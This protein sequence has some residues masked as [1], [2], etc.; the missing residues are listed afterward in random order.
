MRLYDLAP[1][2]ARLVADLDSDECNGLDVEG[3]LAALSEAIEEKAAHLCHVIADLD[4]EGETLRAEEKRLA[5]RRQA[6]ENRAESL[7]DYLRTGMDTAGI[8]KV[9]SATHTITVSDGPQKCVVYDEALVPAQFTRTKV[10]ID[11]RA[12]LDAFK[13]D[14]EVVPGTGVERSRALRIR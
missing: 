14:G 13:N 6:R 1:E 2:Y 4:A 12:I 9:K 10:E 11:K 3:R 5:A 8:T 7:R